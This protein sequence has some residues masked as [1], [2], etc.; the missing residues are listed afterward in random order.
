VTQLIGLQA[1]ANLARRSLWAIVLTGACAFRT[2]P[3]ASQVPPSE[4]PA[5]TSAAQQARPGRPLDATKRGLVELLECPQNGP[6]VFAVL[7]DSRPTDV[8]LLGT[9]SQATAGLRDM[10]VLPAV[11]RS[12]ENTASPRHARLAAMKTLVR[13]FDPALEVDFRTRLTEGADGHIFVMMGRWTEVPGRNGASP[14]TPAGKDKILASLNRIANA[15]P[16]AE[17]RRTAQRLERELKPAS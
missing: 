16:D 14:I 8:S 12:A 4:S 5:C 15:D 9:L 13:L 6:Q 3:V 2:S 10:R 11:I 1:R 7:W 17:I